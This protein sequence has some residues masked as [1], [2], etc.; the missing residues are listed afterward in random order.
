MAFLMSEILKKF[1]KLF[2][3]SQK[4]VTRVLFFGFHVRSILLKDFEKCVYERIF[5][6]LKISLREK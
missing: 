3:L 5:I 2:T 1:A 4:N 6:S